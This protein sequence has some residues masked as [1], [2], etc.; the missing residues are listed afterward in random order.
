MKKII[1]VKNKN[2]DTRSAEQ[3][4]SFDELAD[5]T[6]SH[7]SDVGRVMDFF[8]SRLRK[9]AV[10]HDYTKLDSLN[11][12]Y[13]NFSEAQKTGADFTKMAWY[14]MHVNAERH[15]LHDRTPD[16]VNLF[17]VLERIADITAAG[18]ARTGKFTSDE[19]DPEIL[20]KAYQNTIKMVLARMS[21]TDCFVVDA[22]SLN[23]LIQGGLP[24]ADVSEPVKTNT[25]WE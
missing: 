22:P 14:K 25:K 1:I 4:V 6:K 15:H 19:L 11:L 24:R 10:L 17:D 12:F 3:A 23:A 9:K 18:M 8:I 7:I 20:Q 2:A 13:D 21:V 5:S 16:D